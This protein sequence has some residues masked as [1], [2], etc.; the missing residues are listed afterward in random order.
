[1]IETPN[2]VD[3]LTLLVSLVEPL[4]QPVGD[5]AIDRAALQVPVI[6]PT[7]LA[8]ARWTGASPQKFPIAIAREYES[9]LRIG[10]SVGLGHYAL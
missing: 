4:S 5:A 10:L 3:M 9:A 8:A 2:A 7:A 1:M 6:I